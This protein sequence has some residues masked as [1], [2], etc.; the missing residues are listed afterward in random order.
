M[1]RNEID[2]VTITDT[3]KAF[4]N[5]TRNSLVLLCERNDSPQAYRTLSG[6]KY[7]LRR[8]IFSWLDDLGFLTNEWF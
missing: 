6:K 5:L 8:E 2:L 3:V 1:I 7:Y 4:G